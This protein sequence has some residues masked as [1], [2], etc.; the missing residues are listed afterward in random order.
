MNVQ[1]RLHRYN[2]L[3]PTRLLWAPDQNRS[4][5]DLAIPVSLCVW[6]A[7]HAWNELFVGNVWDLTIPYYFLLCVT[8]WLTMFCDF[9][10]N[11]FHYKLN[12]HKYPHLSEMVIR[13]LW[14]FDPIL[15]QLQYTLV[16][17]EDLVNRLHQFR[18]LSA[19]LDQVIN[20]DLSVDPVI[21][22]VLKGHQ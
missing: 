12:I 1:G 20:H 4:Y 18:I 13:I 3:S 19:N 14:L 17:V 15:D 16:I 21:Q 10:R 22:S 8:S 6:R 5:S 9:L 2:Y 11:T 7:T